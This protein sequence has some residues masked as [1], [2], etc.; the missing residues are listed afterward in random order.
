MSNPAQTLADLKAKLKQ[1]EDKY[2]EILL[3]GQSWRLRNGED[4]RE[5]TNISAAALQDKIE[6]TKRDIAQLEALVNGSGNPNGVRV[7]AKVL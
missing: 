3:T 1:Y 7:R 4:S 6:R 5:L 2:D